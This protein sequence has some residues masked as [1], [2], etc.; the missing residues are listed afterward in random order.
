MSEY[1]FKKGDRVRNLEAN[2]YIEK[3]A[4]GT[5]DENDQSPFVVWDSSNMLTERGQC[6]DRRWA[7]Y[8]YNLE[9][10]TDEHFSDTGK[11]VAGKTEEEWLWI[12]SGQAMH[13]WL[14]NSTIPEDVR[15]NGGFPLPESIAS[16][17]VRYA[18]AL[19]AELKKQGGGE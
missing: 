12:Y 9:L 19:I 13:G 16:D 5:V 10:I 6:A 17:C 7:Q 4:T 11:M 3:G 14:S 18:R 8:E 1:K 15:V 2:E